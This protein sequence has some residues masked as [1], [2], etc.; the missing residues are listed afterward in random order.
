[1]SILKK[2]AKAKR[3]MATEGVAATLRFTLKYAFLGPQPDYWRKFHLMHELAR[4]HDY[5]SI[6]EISTANSGYTYNEIDQSR[7]DVCRRLSYLA[8]DDWTDGASVDYRSSDHDT[9]ECLHQIQAQGLR[10]DIVFLDACH[11]YNCSHRDLR[12]ALELVNDDGIIVVHDCL[13]ENQ[14][15]CA[16][17]RGRYC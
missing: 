2:L 4:I 1:M 14:V 13:P 9:S 7:F 5:R 15:G 16:P 3:M 12:T 6:L 17:F 10:F 8:P 11:E